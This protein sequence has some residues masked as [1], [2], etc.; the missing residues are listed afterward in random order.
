MSQSSTCVSRVLRNA[1]MKPHKT[2]REAAIDRPPVSPYLVCPRPWPLTSKSNQ[3]KSTSEVNFVKFPAVS[4]CM[5]HLLVSSLLLFPAG[6]SLAICICLRLNLSTVYEIQCS[7]MFGTHTQTEPWTG[8]EHHAST[9]LLVT[10]VEAWQVI[11]LRY[12]KTDLPK[13]SE[14]LRRRVV[15][16]A[17]TLYRLHNQSSHGSTTTLVLSNTISH[18]Q[19]VHSFTS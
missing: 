5:K 6:F 3:F 7:Q 11:L 13:C 12:L 2:W 14:E 1:D 19:D 18:L 4:Q 9:A 17:F 15:V 8:W 10:V 16:T